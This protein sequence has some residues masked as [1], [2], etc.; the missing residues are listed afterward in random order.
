MYKIGEFSN[1]TGIPVKTL[2]YYDEIDL[3]KPSYI[4]EDSNYRYYEKKQIEEIQYIMNLK[5][6]NLSLQEIKEYMKK[7]DMEIIENKNKSIKDSSKVIS[8]Y[9]LNNSKYEIEPSNYDEFIDI[10][11]LHILKTPYG[12]AMKENKARYYVINKNGQLYTDI[13]FDIESK[14]LYG[15]PSTLENDEEII[16]IIKQLEKDGIKDVIINIDDSVNNGLLER[17]MRTL[18]V[19]KIE[20]VNEIDKK[21]E[22]NVY[23]QGVK[24]E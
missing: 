16:S 22:R 14:I 12:K 11:G 6:M 20:N 9:I 8:E 5:K 4:E 13:I 23:I 3:F 7:H 18:N 1:I 19:V 24:D 21:G 17:I 2:R 15:G 10:N